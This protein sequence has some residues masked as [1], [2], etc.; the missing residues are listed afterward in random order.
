MPACGKSCHQKQKSDSKTQRSF[1]RMYDQWLAPPP[2]QGHIPPRDKN[3]KVQ[4]DGGKETILRRQVGN[5]LQ[6]TDDEK[7]K[8][9]KDFW[10]QI[11]EDLRG[12]REL[13]TSHGGVS[14]R[15]DEGIYTTSKTTA[16]D[17][18]ATIKLMARYK[19]P[20]PSRINKAILENIQMK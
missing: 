19:D 11:L 5:R 15:L 18:N 9:D 14:S 4:E 17:V 13:L 12:Q 6:I 3:T 10:E 8:F 7:E 16:P 20:G 2:T 1:G